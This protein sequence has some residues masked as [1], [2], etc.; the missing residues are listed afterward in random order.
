M[1]Y[2]SYQTI[3]DN[4]PFLDYVVSVGYSIDPIKS[5][6][7]WIVLKNDSGDKLLWNTVSELYSN[8]LNNTDKGDVIN[9]VANRLQGPVI[10]D[11]SKEAKYQ[12]VQL[13]KTGT[14]SVDINLQ[15][16]I[17]QQKKIVAKKKLLS[18]IAPSEF[19]CIPMTDKTYLTKDRFISKKTLED[20]IFENRLYNTYFK[21][22]ES[23]HIITNYGF[24]KYID[25]KLVGLEVKNKGY[26]SV[27]GNHD[28]LFHTNFKHF[29]KVDCI[30]FAESAIDALSYHELFHN[31]KDLN[32]KNIV[33]LS[34]SGNIYD[35]KAIEVIKLIKSLPL[36][37]DTKFVSI[38]DM[39][40]AGNFYDHYITSELLKE[41]KDINLNFKQVEKTF[42]NYEFH[43][44]DEQKIK[45][46][47]ELTASYNNEVS[48]D[49]KNSYGFY[50]VL[51][52]DKL[53]NTLTLDIPVS[54]TVN[55]PLMT[56]L[57]K[58]FNAQNIGKCH[59]PKASLG[60]WNEHLKQKK[61][62]EYKK[63]NPTQ[64]PVMIEK[65]TRKVK[66]S[67]HR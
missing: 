19:N 44:I 2:V 45:I 29:D 4:N 26:S 42:F 31:H 16:H 20:P 3:K 51:K 15:S 53:N 10:V 60:D 35:T 57:L 22:P 27:Q 30:F 13:L 49:P 1:S 58:T 21:I 50:V 55:T 17:E 64:S 43:S 25:D 65:K 6:A 32:N 41:I 23:G 39:D 62:E 11:K 63:K 5:S 36:N 28:G 18:A 47:K 37:N 33:Y 56:D 40:S 61:R 46:L 24:G 54:I 52:E 66:P 14:N 9:F 59:K 67:I 12:A 38:T 7:K 8:P 48:V 34:T